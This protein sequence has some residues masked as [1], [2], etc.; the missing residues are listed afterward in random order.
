MPLEP[1]VDNTTGEL[2]G[3][4]LNYQ[5]VARLRENGV[6][7]P[8]DSDDALTAAALAESPAERQH[9]MPRRA[10]QWSIEEAEVT[11]GWVKSHKEVRHLV[12]NGDARILGKV[13]ADVQGTTVVDHN[14]GGDRVTVPLPCN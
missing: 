12:T 10:L 6:E 13:L 7:G 9:R 8:E 14:A 2:L 11:Q 5:V 3:I 1:W 4:A